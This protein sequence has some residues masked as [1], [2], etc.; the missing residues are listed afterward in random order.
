MRRWLEQVFH[1]RTKEFALVEAFF[2]FF[3][4][5]GMF[6][7]VG[8]TVGDTLFLSN[9]THDRVPRMLPWVYAGI[10][11]VS[12]L[13]TLLFDLIQ[14]HVSRLAAIVG[15]QVV[16]AA[17][18]LVFRLLVVIDRPAIYFALVVWMEVSALLSITLFF[19]FA[20][21]YFTSRDA[22]RLYGFIAGGMALGT[23]VAGYSLS[24]VVLFIGTRNLLY[25]GGALLLLNAVISWRIYR[26]AT[27][28]PVEIDS[29]DSKTEQVSMKA[30]FERPYV[31]LL[32]LM[33]ALAIV[34]SVVVDYQMKWIAST[35]SEEDLAQ[36]FGTFYGVIGVAQ[37][38]FQFL[39]VPRL[40]RVLGII[41]CLLI[42]PVMIGLL[43]LGLLG[44]SQFGYFGLTLLGFSAAVNF[45]RITLNETLDLPSREMLFLPLPTRLRVRAQPFL[46]GVFASGARALAGLLV[47]GIFT[48]GVAV[49]RLSVVAVFFSIL[50]MITLIRLRPKYRETL[51]S[52]LRAQDMD[53][54]DLQQLVQSAAADPVLEE[55]LHSSDPRVVKFTLD[56]IQNRRVGSLAQTIES[57]LESP[58]RTIAVESLKALGADASP[59]FFSFIRRAFGSG[60][61]EIREAAVMAMCQACGSEV[62][63]DV[64]GLLESDDL[65][66]KHGA[67]V[68][69]ARYLG[70]PGRE[71]ALPWLERYVDSTDIGD[72][73]K[74]AD[75]LGRVAQP[76]FESLFKRLAADHDIRVRLDTVKAIAVS[77]DTELV[78]DLLDAMADHDMRPGVLRALASLQPNAVGPLI[79]RIRNRTIPSV[80]RRILLRVLS[81]I[82][83]PE[84][85]A[86]LWDQI[87]QTDEDLTYRVTA[88]QSL[89]ALRR[90]EGLYHLKLRGFNALVERE[91]E[92]LALFNQARD[93]VAGADRF[94]VQV[95]QDHARLTIEL[96]L[97]LFGLR[98]DPRQVDRILFNL[99]AESPTMRA[100]A[101]ELL[102]EV[103]PR[104]MALRVVVLLQSTVEIP[105]VAEG[106]GLRPETHRRLF[107]AE[108]WIRAATVYHLSKG[109][110]EPA[111]IKGIE[112][113][114]RECAIYE[115]LDT[116]AFLKGVPLFHD[117]PTNFLLEQTEIAEWI[118]IKG[119]QVLFKQGDAG[120]ALYIVGQGTIRI[121]IQGREV[122]RM[123]PWECIGEMA[124][125][126]DQ[127]RS[128]TVEAVSVVRL[129]RVWKARFQQLLATQP[130]IAKAL[131]RTLDR[132]IRA[133]QAPSKATEPEPPDRSTLRMSHIFM[134]TS[135]DLHHLIP[136]IS[137]LGQVDL[138]KGLPVQSLTRLATI[139]QEIFYGQG[140]EI[141]RQG[142]EGDALYLVRS[143]SVEVLVD[144][145]KVATLGEYAPIGEMALLSNLP[146]SA[147]V[148]VVQDAR[149]HRLWSEDFQQLLA[150]EPEVSL[151]LLKTLVKRLRTVS[152]S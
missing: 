104:K 75:L 6:Y 59:E 4:G 41:P 125:L 34:I 100:R 96:V 23:V 15:T 48:M 60:H 106:E 62:L 78:S 67:I 11:A 82:G 45:V 26:F 79:W 54:C 93:E 70:K 122:A 88:A 126:D 74:A 121:L 43:S 152:A 81:R 107:L 66:L 57:L 103:L 142:D 55:L 42:F 7:T 141:F 1:I 19:S 25:V 136:T 68:G 12:L 150:T 17:S 46:N 47:L 95:F 38:L 83:G 132:R 86:A 120:D 108:S 87:S 133:T 49:D 138:F 30:I 148:R 114:P 50:L 35:K 13:A 51:A 140:D 94:A 16:L 151:A 112:L 27:P 71:R 98:Y 14:N 63:Q 18:V 77:G 109:Q 145:R 118:E 119:G 72:R 147:T 21:D 39:L 85:A 130:A 90:R 84:A 134:T 37:L 65:A 28:A 115:R 97:S 10:A 2:L 3:I 102:D 36:F 89:S 124:L 40:L 110:P 146:R 149:L 32:A 143:G 20:G 135:A 56:L 76:G 52:A 80:D 101:I 73:L 9:L 144:G 99:F 61:P 44:A 69:L 117:V 139:V 92:S 29:G 5:I 127:P 33:L 24:A 116:I 64:S 91:L 111:R 137:F 113:T 58:D 131:L 105:S 123:G 8:A 31:K 53:T 129:L 128:A 22:R